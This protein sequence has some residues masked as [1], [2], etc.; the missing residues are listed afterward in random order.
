MSDDDDETVIL[1]GATIIF[2]RCALLC[3]ENLLFTAMTVA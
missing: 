2:S 3:N 1:A